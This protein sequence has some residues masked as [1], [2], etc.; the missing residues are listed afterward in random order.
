MF[1]AIIENIVLYFLNA[2]KWVSCGHVDF[3]G[4]PCINNLHKYKNCSVNEKF[5]GT[6]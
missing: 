1:S 6:Y 4:T 2:I 5:C 3:I